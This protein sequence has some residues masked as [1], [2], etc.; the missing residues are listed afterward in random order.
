MPIAVRRSSIGLRL[1]EGERE[2]GFSSN[3]LFGCAAERP[4]AQHKGAF[5]VHK[6]NIYLVP[7]NALNPFLFAGFRALLARLAGV[8]ERTSSA[9]MRFYL[10]R[11]SR[12]AKSRK[13]AIRGSK[14]ERIRSSKCKFLRRSL[15]RTCSAS[16][17]TIFLSAKD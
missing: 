14:N 10:V 12:P 4:G 1:A 9:S 3:Y 13:N 5:S 17:T 15:R 2:C 11:R 6:L 8:A 16:S 7:S